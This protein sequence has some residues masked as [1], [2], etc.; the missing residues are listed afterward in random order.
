MRVVAPAVAHVVARVVHQADT[1]I[2]DVVEGA[3]VGAGFV[4]G[5]DGEHRPA[6]IGRDVHG[7]IH[8][9]RHRIDQG[10]A[11]DGHAARRGD[12]LAIAVGQAALMHQLGK[13][14]GRGTATAEAGG[15][16]ADVGRGGVG[17]LSEVVQCRQAELPV[18]I[19]AAAWMAGVG[20]TAAFTNPP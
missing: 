20:S 8:K 16:C 19:F 17:V 12:D 15:G 5:N 10:H 7:C 14:D 3:E 18:R 6:H 13:A 1:R 2:I 9:A 4:V 11:G